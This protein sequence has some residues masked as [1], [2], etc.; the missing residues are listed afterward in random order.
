MKSIKDDFNK[1]NNDNNDYKK[2]WMSVFCKTIVNP[3][4]PTQSTSKT[5][6]NVIP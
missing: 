5:P 6:P 2:W 3:K 1:L 4:S